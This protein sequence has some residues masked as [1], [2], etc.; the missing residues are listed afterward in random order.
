MAKYL[1]V[2][3]YVEDG[4]AGGGRRP[5]KTLIPMEDLEGLDAKEREEE[6]YAYVQNDY[7]ADAQK[8]LERHLSSY[9][10]RLHRFKPAPDTPDEEM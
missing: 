8:V 1:E 10:R 2:T 7:G 5:H 9:R 3:W 4:Y 6:I